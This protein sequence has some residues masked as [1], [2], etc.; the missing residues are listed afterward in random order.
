VRIGLL[1]TGKIIKEKS[2][3]CQNAAGTFQS[4]LKHHQPNLIG[5]DVEWNG[6]AIS[7][8]TYAALEW[9]TNHRVAHLIDKSIEGACRSSTCLSAEPFLNGTSIEVLEKDWIAGKGVVGSIRYIGDRSKSNWIRTVAELGPLVVHESTSN[10]LSHWG[11]EDRNNAATM[12]QIVGAEKGQ[13][14]MIKPNPF[15]APLADGIIPL[16]PMEAAHIE[17][18]DADGSESAMRARK[19]FVDQLEKERL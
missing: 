17:A 16:E 10:P 3:F 11:L 2:E 19:T 5:A 4:H 14:R 12:K 8:P 6:I 9:E 7:A 15:D 13:L 1:S 18:L